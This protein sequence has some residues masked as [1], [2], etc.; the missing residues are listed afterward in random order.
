LSISA[1]ADAGT[2][3]TADHMTGDYTSARMGIE[4]ART[5]RNAAGLTRELH[6]AYTRHSG[7]YHH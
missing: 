4:L 6:A 1:F 3:K 5:P 2:P 7:G